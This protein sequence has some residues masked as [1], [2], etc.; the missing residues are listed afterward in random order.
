MDKQQILEKLA[1][2]IVDTD[3]ELARATAKEAIASGV[4]PL[5]AVEQGLS[6][7]MGTI[8]DL[9]GR[10]E[11][12]LP[13]LLLSANAFNE[14]M[15]VLKPELEARKQQIAQTATVVLGTVQG[16]LHSIGKNIVAT[17]LE[18]SGFRV[19]DLG[20]DRSPLDFVQEAGKANADVIALSCL[21]TTTMPSQK[22]VIDVLK[23][24]KLRDK[25]L[26]VVGGAP[27]SQK[28]ADEIGADGY[29]QSAVDAVALVKRLVN[30]K[31]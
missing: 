31:K 24:M 13:E 21:M 18:T 30:K 23:E 1:Q 10:G 6:K 9:F 14:A 29:G 25:Y 27:T 3:P 22:A 12:F 4:S 15:Q 26:V 28:W 19:V 8:G 16:D 5:E 7:G 17:L 20:V 2:A 11:V